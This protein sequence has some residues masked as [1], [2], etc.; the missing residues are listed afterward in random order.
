M[1]NRQ[2]EAIMTRET[3][4]KEALTLSSEDRMKLL[5]DLWQSFGDDADAVALTPAQAEDLQKR[6]DEEDAGQAEFLPW[7]VV[8]EQLRRRE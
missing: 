1:Y 8:R 4:L 5:E 2:S 3:V 7:E 6:L